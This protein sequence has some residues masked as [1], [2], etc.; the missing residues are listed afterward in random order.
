MKKLLLLL[1]VLTSFAADAQFVGGGGRRVTIV[2]GGDS[3]GTGAP[4][5]AD[6]INTALGYQPFNP[7]VALINPAFIQSLS[8]EKVGLGNVDNTPDIEKPLSTAM[9]NALAGKLS[10]IQLGT[11]NNQS[12]V[13]SN[14]T[15]DVTNAT[16]LTT[17]TIPNGRLSTDVTR[18][19]SAQRLS[20]KIFYFSDNNQLIGFPISSIS[21]LQSSLDAKMPTFTPTIINGVS[22]T[23]GSS[24]TLATPDASSI[25]TGQFAKGRM[26][27]GTM[28]VGD[29]INSD[30]TPITNVAQSGVKFLPDSISRKANI[31]GIA[32]INGVSLYN[33]GQN[34]VVSGGGS[35]TDASALTTGKL[36]VARLPDVTLLSTGTYS[37]PSWLSITPTYIGLGNVNNTS[38]AN[39]PVSTAQQTVFDTKA[40]LT[41]ANIFSAANTFSGNVGLSTATLSTSLLPTANA[42]GTIGN[43]SLRFAGVYSSLFQS[44]GNLQLRSGTTNGLISILQG[45]ASDK[46]AEF[47]TTGKLSL[48]PKGAAPVDTTNA[49]LSVN[50]KVTITDLMKLG[51]VN[52]Y[53]DETAAR[54]AG[55][56]EGYVYKDDENVLRIVGSDAPQF[57]RTVYSG[58]QQLFD[59]PDDVGEQTWQA[60]SAGQLYNIKYVTNKPGANMVRFQVDPGDVWSGDINTANQETGCGNCQ[61][62][63]TGPNA[64]LKERSE[65][66][67]KGITTPGG[68]DQWVSYSFMVEPGP[69]VVY[70]N[71]AYY[72]AT[73]QW[74]NADDGGPVPFL[75]N[76]NGAN[77]L[78]LQTKGFYNQNRF[79]RT[80]VTLNPRGQWNNVVIRVKFNTNRTAPYNGSFTWWVNG[81]KYDD[82]SAMD[83]GTATN[84][85]N[86][87]QYKVG[88]Y[89][90]AGTAGTTPPQKI[91]MAVR[92]V[93][94]RHTSGVSLMSKVGTPDP[95]P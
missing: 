3:S 71:E 40:N 35:T 36:N 88:I 52:T 81:V 50:G 82:I 54:A 86:K 51:K 61:N 64:Q 10:S 63:S 19:S 23:A 87:G 93:N 13:G 18:N 14:I 72:C 53:T 83:I 62:P 80:N 43:T 68:V 12:I 42:V 60:Q 94:L 8:K 20:N 70:T 85:D 90:T 77:K 33:G 22:A 45:G 46:I 89:R 49:Q 17:G 91:S 73:G 38:D 15:I 84:D 28:F 6:R 74:H 24:L 27:T 59:Y 39:K 47:S 57:T 65:I 56:V 21:N 2:M 92:Y 75:L 16:N 44:N 48:F 29:A 37:N 25:Q 7:N 30:V 26:P 4:L 5:T 9:I 95:I 66:Y 41:T 1:L 67:G 78:M 32:Q 69:D 58:N 34:I 55:L 31:A 11:I 76:Y 79:D